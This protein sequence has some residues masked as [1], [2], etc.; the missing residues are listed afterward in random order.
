M[1]TDILLT[2]ELNRYRPERTGRTDGHTLILFRVQADRGFAMSRFVVKRMV[3]VQIEYNLK[4]TLSWCRD[5][6][7]KGG[8]RSAGYGLN[9]RF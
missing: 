2:W 5:N 3:L 9:E 1:Q 7:K 4:L 6:I 8:E